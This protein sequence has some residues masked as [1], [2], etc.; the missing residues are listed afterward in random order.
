MESLS[1]FLSP[2]DDLEIYCEEHGIPCIGLCSNYLC[3]EKIKFLCMKCV[4]SG[5]TCITK[6][7]H[8]LITLAEMLYRFFIKE[9]N[10]SIDLLEIQTMNHIIKEYDKVE[11]NN[12][13][14]QF[15]T[16]KEDNS[17]KM[18]EIQNTFYEL[19]NI[20]IEN[21]RIKNNEK[22]DELNEISKKNIEN[23][24]D[25]QL[26]L[27]IKMPEVDKKNLDNN[28][29]LIYFMNEG[30]K[31]S[32]PKNFINNVK[33]LSDSNKF[34]EIS[35][36][37]NKKIYSNE[38]T[39]KDEE[40][41]KKLENK[42][43]SL[44]KALELKFDEKMEQ[45]EKEIILPKDNP[46]IYSSHSSA[47]KFIR[48][49]KELIYKEDL[50]S[51]AHKTN[52]IDKVF[53]AFK[54]FSGEPLVVWGTPQ[55]SIEFYDLEKGKIIKSIFK[56]HN[57]TIFSCRHYSDSKNRIDYIISS[58]YDRA[59]KVW[60]L[61]TFNY[62][63]NISNA[64]SGYYIYS[65][66]ILCD[67]KEDCNYVIT[68]APNEYMKVWDFKGKLL[69]SFGQNDEST[70]FIDIY[71]DNFLKKYY[72][73]NANSTDVKS[74][75]FKN[76]ELYHKYRGE[77]QTWHMSAVVNETKDQNILIES[78]GNGYIRMWE[79][80]AGT[81]LKIISASPNLNLRG[82]CL[83]NDDY[84]LAAG[85]DYQVK[86]FDLVEGKFVKTLKAHTSTVCS[87]EKIVHPKYGECLISQGL[88]GKLRVWVLP[89]KN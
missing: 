88:D 80:H 44:L 21:F 33:L 64:H 18:T 85:N 81:L 82:I 74:Y 55:Y 10:K 1:E 73:I 31:L 19:I 15:K 28:Q 43:D 7:K 41:K 45:L 8:E 36:K 50:C 16:V 52:S 9:E 61:K 24:K 40:K 77:P 46:I 56:A 75:S 89:Q 60:D 79:F 51:T 20:L 76:G 54:A 53:C 49:P 67:E 12:I 84:L 78:D 47:L 37:L 27:D 35:N 65:V 3:K 70:Y 13:L 5:Q 32:S 48:D 87:L 23:E 66:C 25:I 71:F 72:V 62:I 30:Y 38:I 14:T 26:L 42:I 17:L 39:T 59:V 2:F 83:W 29:K 6:E 57:Q 86:L 69:R 34:I 4:K 11:L 63:V 22:I 58:S 68:S